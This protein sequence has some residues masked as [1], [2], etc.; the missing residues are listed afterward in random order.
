MMQRFVLV[1]SIGHRLVCDF[2]VAEGEWEMMEGIMSWVSCPGGLNEDDNRLSSVAEK[3]GAWEQW[4]EEL[5]MAP[6][7]PDGCWEC[8][9]EISLQDSGEV[10]GDIVNADDGT[11]ETHV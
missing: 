8:V 5:T 1:C 3:E 4:E 11:V 6:N 9:H 7:P 10:D 2:V